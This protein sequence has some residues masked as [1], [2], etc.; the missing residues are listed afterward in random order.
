MTSEK[1]LGIDNLKDMLRQH[2][3]AVVKSEV[4]D[5]VRSYLR[6]RGVMHLL[7][8]TRLSTKYYLIKVNDAPCRAECVNSC[9]DTA[10]GALNHKCYIVCLDD[11]FRER[12]SKVVENL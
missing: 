5:Q 2:G 11:C 9:R 3:F 8:I 1:L 12:L 6:I 7:T 4:I 10:S